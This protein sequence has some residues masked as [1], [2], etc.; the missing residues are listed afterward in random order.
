MKTNSAE[1]KALDRISHPIPENEW[2]TVKTQH[3]ID[4]EAVRQR[5]K[6]R[7]IK[8]NEQ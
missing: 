6:Q 7:G 2:V 3:D 8:T 5:I 1:A 4:L